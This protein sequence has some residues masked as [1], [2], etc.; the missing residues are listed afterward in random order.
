MSRG[1]RAF[2]TAL[3]GLALVLGPAAGA[4]ADDRPLADPGNNDAMLNIL[5]SN[6]IAYN[7]AQT[8]DEALA[9]SDAD[10]TLVV[11]DDE[12]G[13][14]PDQI[15]ELATATWGRVIILTT[16]PNVLAAFAPGVTVAGTAEQ[17]DTSAGL[18]PACAEPDAATAGTVRAPGFTSYYSI[19]NAGTA[20]ATAGASPG[21][22]STAG[23]SP[24]A[25]ASASA[26]ATTTIPTF[27]SNVTGCY[28]VSAGKGGHGAMM[29]TLQNSRTGGDVILLGNSAF[30]EN[31]YLADDGDA[32]L[33]LRLFGA[34][35][36]LVWLAET[37][38]EDPNLGD[39]GGSACGDGQSGQSADGGSGQFTTPTALPAPSGAAAEQVNS[40]LP[41]WIWWTV[42]QLVIAA[43]ALAYWRGRRMGRL[44]TESLPVRVRAAE[45][46]EGHANLYRR[47]R[48]HGRAADLLRAATARRIAPLLGLPAG[49]AGR[50]PQTLVA[51]LAARLGRNPEQV[52]AV[53]AGV[54][55]QTEAELVRLT[56]QLDRLE[57]EVRSR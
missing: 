29:V 34:H 2:V 11:N 19:G 18:A 54:V 1:H 43:A 25:T 32:A 17:S 6:G 39:C 20:T 57:Q 24:G 47:A 23:T 51:P 8:A 38:T 14:S 42:L 53:L 27:V 41:H 5:L 36:D 16:D 9:Y 13:L 55:P 49:P 50:S 12:T 48:A 7:T 10:S 46:V 35:G 26:S 28:Q 15:A 37:F 52:H 31:Q 40:L 3:A 21:A 4:R 56:D 33:A 44:V 30:T 45:T 22:G